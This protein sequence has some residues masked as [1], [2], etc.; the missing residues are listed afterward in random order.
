MADSPRPQPP[1][2]LTILLFGMSESG[3]S[4]LLGALVQAAQSQ[5]QALGGQLTG[6]PQGMMELHQRLL[7]T[8]PRPTREEVV[9]YSASFQG[10]GG[11]VALTLFDCDGRVARDYLVG[12][13]D[14]ETADADLTR[15]IQ[16]AD[17]L[18][19]TM[20]A[21]TAPTQLDQDFAQFGAFLRLFEDQRGRHNETAGLPVY[22]VL[23]KCDLLAKPDDTSSKWM[24]RIEEA[25]RKIDARFRDF[26]DTPPSEQAG[27]F[28]VLDLHIWATAV[29]RPALSDRPA[30]ATEPFGVAELFRQTIDSAR[31][32]Q[33]HRIRSGR[34]MIV[35]AALVAFL[36]GFLG[37]LGTYFF[38][39]RPSSD[40]VALENAVKQ[41]LP[42]GAAERLREPVDDRLNR[43][44]AIE[45]DPVFPQLAPKT[46]EDISQAVADLTAYLAWSKLFQQVQDPRHILNEDEL[47]RNEKLIAA[48]SF[49]EAQ[50]AAWSETRLGQRRL[51]WQ[52][53]LSLLRAAIDD[54]IKW[55]HAQMQEGEQLRKAGGLVIAQT[56]T[57][58]ERDDWF[59][60]VKQFLNRDQRHQRIDRLPGA[61]GL[62][63]DAVYRFDRVDQTR[64]EWE[65]VKKALEKVREQAQ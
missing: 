32:F 18:I 55:M 52:R 21:S 38:I 10:P 24:Q 53:D 16:R 41:T 50:K 29:K 54:E 60:Q 25:K 27:L 59:A 14:L 13:K 49:P 57:P 48:T 3:K 34:K 39:H 22:L 33:R 56:I 35:A 5:Q 9:P 19:L 23:T 17:T 8:Q 47:A 1:R 45:A 26:L 37:V 6:L 62:T 31:T 42:V 36:V 51:Q 2:G 20:D 65:K 46:Q 63:F 58:K 12:I 28:G 64:L 15:V 61:P 40:L 7:D 43:L 4:S 11:S 30:K 44:R